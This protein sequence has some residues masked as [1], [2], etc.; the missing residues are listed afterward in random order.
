MSGKKLL[1][2]GGGT[3]YRVSDLESKNDEKKDKVVG[4]KEAC[5]PEFTDE[6][7]SVD[8]PD[9]KYLGLLMNVPLNV[10]VEIGK[11]KKT[12]SEIMRL[13]Q[14]SII[15]LEKQAGSSVDVIANDQVIARGD[16][17]VI[18]EN[19]GVRITEIIPSKNFP[20]SENQ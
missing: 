5:F 3:M 19:F 11:T 16:V 9:D 15:T 2:A 8:I 18:E 13:S 10:R 6:T 7:T 14:G 1:F 4:V 20:L 17:I 12:M